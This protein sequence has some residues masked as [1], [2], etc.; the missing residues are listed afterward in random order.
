MSDLGRYSFAYDHSTSCMGYYSHI[1]YLIC[2]RPYLISP[3]LFSRSSVV[4][5]LFLHQTMQE[6]STVYGMPGYTGP[7]RT[8]AELGACSASS[9]ELT[10]RLLCRTCLHDQSCH[11]MVHVSKVSMEKLFFTARAPARMRN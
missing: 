8:S 2:F 9:S 11:G 4:L 6:C 5:L 1:P 10:K 3:S 7:R